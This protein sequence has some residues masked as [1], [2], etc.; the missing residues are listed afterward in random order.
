MSVIGEK[1]DTF[2]AHFIVESASSSFFFN[3][4]KNLYIVISDH[5]YSVMCVAG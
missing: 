3:S 4:L 2:L 5:I 1:G